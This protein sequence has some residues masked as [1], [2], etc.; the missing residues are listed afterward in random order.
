MHNLRPWLRWLPAIAMMAILFGFSS[1]S[2]EEQSLVPE[3]EKS[4]SDQWIENRFGGI[5]FSY[6]DYEI[7]VD[8][9]GGASFIEFF[10]R[11]AAHFGS[12]ALLAA[13]LVYALGG[14]GRSNRRC[15]LFAI[16]IAFLYACT[17]ELHQSF[18]PGRTA[19]VQDVLLDTIG[20]ACGAAFTILLKSWWG[21][22]KDRRA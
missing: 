20:A 3:I 10:I 15:L 5:R 9:V 12:Y 18:T 11:K 7:S 22:W 6:G 19:M 13:F 2:Y 21:N 8:S 14:R 4:T 1:Q 16:L 17:D